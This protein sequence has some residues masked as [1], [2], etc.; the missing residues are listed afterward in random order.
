MISSVCWW[1]HTDMEGLDHP[2]IEELPGLDSDE[3]QAMHKE[4][5]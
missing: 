2:D 1:V 5:E 3:L 4:C